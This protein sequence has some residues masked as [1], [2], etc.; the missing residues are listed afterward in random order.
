MTPNVRA[1]CRLVSEPASAMWFDLGTLNEY[2]DGQPLHQERL[3]HLPFDRCA[4]AGI[5]ADGDLFALGLIAGQNRTISVAGCTRSHRG[6]VDLQPFVYLEHE[7]ELKLAKASDRD[8]ALRAMVIIDGWL[9]NLDATGCNGYQPS[10]PENAI[11][12]ERIRKGKRPLSYN[13]RTVVIAPRKPSCPDQGGTHASPRLHDRRGH[14]RK[15][16]S[17]KQV[18]VKACK[19]GDASQGTVFKDY[20]VKS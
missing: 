8:A 19:V 15:H 5:D 20:K 2:S 9:S 3:L 18:W 11:N 17:G 12:R 14:W 4:L 6:I 16:P 1:A 7:G 13:W 10:I